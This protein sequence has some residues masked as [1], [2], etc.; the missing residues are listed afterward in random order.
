MA[1]WRFGV[2]YLM[3]KHRACVEV[4][5]IRNNKEQWRNPISQT[6]AVRIRASRMG[7][8]RCF[9]CVAFPCNWAGVA[10]NVHLQRARSQTA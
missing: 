3:A 6:T 8:F 4:K 10:L 2:E 9:A 1:S 7:Q 5:L